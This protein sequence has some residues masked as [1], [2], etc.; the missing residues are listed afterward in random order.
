MTQSSDGPSATNSH[1]PTFLAFRQLGFD[2][3]FLLNDTTQAALWRSDESL[4]QD[5]YIIRDAV[6]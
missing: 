6:D 2:L 1:E 5:S 4:N 3:A